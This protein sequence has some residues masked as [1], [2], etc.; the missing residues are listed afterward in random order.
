[1]FNI[2]YRCPRTVARHENGPLHESRR[3]YLEHVAAQGAALHTLRGAAGIIYR[4]AIWMKLDESSPVKRKEVERAS[5]RW[6]HRSY[7]N[8]NCRSPEQTDKEFRQTT[9]HWLR[10]AGRLRESD[11]APAPHQQEIDALCHYMDVERGLS[12]ATITTVRQ[13]LRKFFKHTR[14]QQL[15]KLKIADVDSRSTRLSARGASAWSRMGGCA[16]APGQY[17][18]ESEGRHP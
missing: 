2:L 13:S 12:P 5:K 17:G 6:A 10:F 14:V 1:M 9:C 4:A 8:A 15:S 11:R 7:R 18:N 3:R 16:K